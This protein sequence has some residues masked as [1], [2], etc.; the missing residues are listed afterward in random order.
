MVGWIENWTY[1]GVWL[2]QTSAVP[3][4][5]ESPS[6]SLRDAVLCI[7]AAVSLTHTLLLLSFTAL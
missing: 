5:P 4:K 7:T 1:E 6:D 3:Q 2:I